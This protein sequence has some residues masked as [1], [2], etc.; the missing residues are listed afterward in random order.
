MTVKGMRSAHAATR[1]PVSN[2]LGGRGSSGRPQQGGW[3][4]VEA[5]AAD[6]GERPAQPQGERPAGRPQGQRPG[7]GGRPSGGGFRGGRPQ[8]QRREG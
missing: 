2:P 7:G 3:H 8:G 5:G 1:G 4:P 6:R